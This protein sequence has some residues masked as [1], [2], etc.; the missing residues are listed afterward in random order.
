MNITPLRMGTKTKLGNLI[1]KHNIV[2]TDF[3]ERVGVST[4]T[5]SRWCN[6][7]DNYEFQQFDYSKIPD[8][9]NAFEKLGVRVHESEI[10]EM[11][12]H[13]PFVSV[14]GELDRESREIERYIDDISIPSTWHLPRSYYAIVEIINSNFRKYHLVDTSIKYEATSHM[15]IDQAGIIVREGR[16]NSDVF[17]GVI[18]RNGDKITANDCAN[19]LKAMVYEAHEIKHIYLLRGSIL[20]KLENGS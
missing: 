14:R 18:G 2:Q 4:V 8:I 20:G 10:I 1:T 3:A 13:V 6:A 15:V 19:E 5:L 7:N 16:K 12:G 17:A 11:E 9:L